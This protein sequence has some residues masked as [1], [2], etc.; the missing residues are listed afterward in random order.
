MKFT[1]MKLD[2]CVP[3]LM[4]YKIVL[5]KMQ[6]DGLNRYTLYLYNYQS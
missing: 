5:F 1:G 4:G 3:L 6:K 2:L